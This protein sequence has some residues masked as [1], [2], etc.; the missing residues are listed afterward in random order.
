M[1]KRLFAKELMKRS[2]V[3]TQIQ[4]WIRELVDEVATPG[5]ELNS[6]LREVVEHRIGG[7][8]K[9]RMSVLYDVTEENRDVMIEKLRELGFVVTDYG[10]GDVIVE[11]IGFSVPEREE[12]VYLHQLGLSFSDIIREFETYDEEVSTSSGSV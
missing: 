12:L 6:M 2:Y 4:I 5:S 11:L 10:N 3:A 7:S 1:D 9:L 8:Q